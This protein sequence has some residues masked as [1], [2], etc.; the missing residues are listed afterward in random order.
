VNLVNKIFSYDLSYTEVT[1]TAEMNDYWI[2][3]LED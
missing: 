2:S 3:V 1:K